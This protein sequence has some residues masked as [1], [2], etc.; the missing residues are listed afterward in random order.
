MN[1]PAEIAAVLALHTWAVVGL[2]NNPDRAAFGVAKLLQEKGHLIIP[3]Y[4]RA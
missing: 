1:T 4:P 2:G 3:I